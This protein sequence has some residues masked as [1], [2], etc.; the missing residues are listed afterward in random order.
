MRKIILAGIIVAIVIGVTA[1]V[2]FGMAFLVV[3]FLSIETPVENDQRPDRPFY[4][5]G[6]EYENLKPK[7][8]KEC[9]DLVEQINKMYPGAQRVELFE[10]WLD[11]CIEQEPAVP[12]LP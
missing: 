12:T 2:F 5:E 9:L 7:K 6:E 3:S 10:L 1:S 4:L 8:S 11:D